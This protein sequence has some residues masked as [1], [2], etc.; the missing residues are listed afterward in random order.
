MSC[1]TPS[2]GVMV[3]VFC[4]FL[5]MLLDELNFVHSREIVWGERE[6]NPLS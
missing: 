5:G 3:L 6:Q 4:R 2:L 1:V